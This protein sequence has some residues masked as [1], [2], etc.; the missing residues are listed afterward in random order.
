M[1]SLNE[2]EFRMMSRYIMSKSLHPFG[3]VIIH[4]KT[5][6]ERKELIIDH[7]VQVKDQNILVDDPFKYVGAEEIGECLYVRFNGKKDD[8]HFALDKIQLHA[9]ENDIRLKQESYIVMLETSGNTCT[10]D[11]FVPLR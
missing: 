11:Y 7:I 1:G 2:E 8:S 5:D 6:V 3:P 4:Q 10:I 9:Y